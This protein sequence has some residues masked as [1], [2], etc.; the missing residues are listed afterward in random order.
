VLL[1]T[2]HLCGE[3]SALRQHRGQ[4]L[5]AGRIQC[6]Y[7]GWTYDRSGQVVVVL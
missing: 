5:R 2:L 6:G 7:H 1:L 4:A 3:L